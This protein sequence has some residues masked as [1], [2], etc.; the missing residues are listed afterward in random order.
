MPP[1]KEPQSQPPVDLRALHELYGRETTLELLTMSVKEARELLAIIWTGIPQC[2]EREVADAA[3]QLKG[4]S[5]TMTMADMSDLS[6][7]LEKNA[8]Q[9]NWEEAAALHARLVTCFAALESYV[10]T[11]P[12]TSTP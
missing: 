3:H 8:R 12:T 11:L 4:L 7:E 10:R 5:L 1:D 2:Q 6:L 9:G